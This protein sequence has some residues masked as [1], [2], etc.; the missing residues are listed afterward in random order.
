M[1]FLDR[2][3]IAQKVKRRTGKRLSKIRNRPG[4]R[5]KKR[6]PDFEKRN[7]GNGKIAGAIGAG[8]ATIL[9]DT[10]GLPF[11]ASVDVTNVE[12]VEGGQLYTVNVNA[13]SQNMAEARAFIDSSTGFL[14]YLTDEFDIEGVEVLNHRMAR[15]TYQIEVKVTV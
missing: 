12:P 10:V 5:I 11:G 8:I 9:E 3:P 14:S 15:D 13:P 4:M 2:E 6:T 1:N 7:F